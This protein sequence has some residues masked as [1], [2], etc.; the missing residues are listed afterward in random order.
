MKSFIESQVA[1]CPL[2]WISCGKTSDNRVNHL[3]EHA[4]RTVYNDI[5]STFEMRA[6]I[7][8]GCPLLN[9]TVI[10]MLRVRL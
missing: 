9:K 5:A 10:L 1:Y 8:T 2:V 4:L 6:G 3:H 7:A